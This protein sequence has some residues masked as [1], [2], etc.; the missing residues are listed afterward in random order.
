MKSQ[1]T[2]KALKLS[3]FTVA[4]NVLE[5]LVA[6][7]FGFVTGSIALTA[8]GFDSFVESISGGVMIWRFSQ[9]SLSEEEEER[10]EKKA[11]KLVGYSFYILGAYILFES[12]KDLYFQEGPEP[13]VVGIVIAVLSL[14][15]MHFL[16]RLKHAVGKALNSKSLIADSK[17]TSLCTLMSVTLLIG[18]GLNVLFGLWWADPV[19]GVFLAILS[20]KEGYTALTTESIC[21][22]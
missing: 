1:L 15:I 20:F 12:L 22:C 10:V 4:Y 21:E 19:A 14:L 7:V 17:Q 11:S 13:S 2:R 6:V 5:G 3:Y 8:F 16:A 18:V 9:N